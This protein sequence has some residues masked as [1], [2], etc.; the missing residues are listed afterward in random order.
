MEVLAPFLARGGG[1]KALAEALRERK[2][3]VGSAAKALAALQAAGSSDQ[4]LTQVLSKAAGIV[5]VGPVY[6]EIFVRDLASE[7]IRGDAGRG[8]QV[9]QLAGCTACHRMGAKKT[10]VSM[11]GPD[12]RTIGNTLSTDRIIE[13]VLWPGRAVKEGY[14]LLQVTTKDGTVHQGY[15]QR[16][17]SEDVFLKPLVR[18]E[19][20]RIPKNQVHVKA[21]TGSAMPAGLTAA[22]NRE[23]LRDL[24]CFLTGLGRK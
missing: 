1:P 10:G 20:I 13:E 15:E 16:S 3:K 6:S 22:L 7:S 17:R 11:I 24:I 8:R 5:V 4:G 18:A 9:F 14:S 19:T 12:L 21:Q 2:L 23:Q